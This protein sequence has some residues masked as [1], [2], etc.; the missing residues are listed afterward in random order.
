MAKEPLICYIVLA[1]NFVIEAYGEAQ[2]IEHVVKRYGR[3]AQLDRVSASEAEGR[4]F[5]FPL[6]YQRNHLDNLLS[7]FN[8]QC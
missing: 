3:V 7:I 1:I 2:K 8:N 6:A 5:E 4:G